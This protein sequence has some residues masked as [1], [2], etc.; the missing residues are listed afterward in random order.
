VKK[1]CTHYYISLERMRKR[2]FRLMQI[3]G[4]AYAG[5]MCCSETKTKKRFKINYSLILSPAALHS[6]STKAP[7]GKSLTAKA[8]LAGGLSLNISAYSSLTVE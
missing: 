1:I 3:F 8:I 5:V 7:N 6:I 4:T 2:K